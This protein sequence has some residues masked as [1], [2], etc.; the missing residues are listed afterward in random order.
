MRLTFFLHF[1]VCF[2]AY[3]QTTGRLEFE[4]ASVK[5]SPADP[6]GSTTGCSGGPGTN[7]PGLF[8]CS[9]MTLANLVGL[10]YRIDFNQLSAPDWMTDTRFVFDLRAKLLP[11]A[12][13]QQFS[14]MF[15]NLLTDRFKLAVH[16]DTRETQQYD[17]V[18]AKNGPKFKASAPAGSPAG[19]SALQKNGCPALPAGQGLTVNNGQYVLHIPDWSMAVFSTQLAYLL[20]AHVT[21]ATGLTDKYD[22][23]MCW[24]PED[25]RDAAGPGTPAAP[26][27]GP[28]LQQALQDQLGLRLESKRGPVEFIVVEHAEKLPTEN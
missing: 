11:G 1:C 18:V 3:G 21:D 4:V 8:T 23:A 17:L 12:T 2:G 14:V 15:Q 27:S 20:R 7:D 19:P 6:K 26:D 24:A 13:K 5:P 16:R 22:I 25:T 10:A 9:N 28:T